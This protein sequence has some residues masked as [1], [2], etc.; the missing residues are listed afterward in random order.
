MWSNTNL[1][2]TCVGIKKTS[3]IAVV[4]DAKVVLDEHFQ[5]Q[6]GRQ[7]DVF[8]QGKEFFFYCRGISILKDSECMSMGEKKY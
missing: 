4:G 2:I 7:D 6:V 3:C 1:I 5:V 8:G